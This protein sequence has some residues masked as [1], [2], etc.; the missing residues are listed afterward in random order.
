MTVSEVK[1]NEHEMWVLYSQ[2]DITEEFLAERA[3]GTVPCPICGKTPK[4]EY[5]PPLNN[6]EFWD[7][8]DYGFYCDHGGVGQKLEA[9]LDETIPDARWYWEN[10]TVPDWINENKDD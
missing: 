3:K 9:D 8:P 10:C 2:E 4:I 1:V 7:G 6:D 5:F